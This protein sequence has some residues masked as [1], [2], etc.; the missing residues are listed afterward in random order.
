MADDDLELQDPQTLSF[1]SHFWSE[2]FI[3]ASETKPEERKKGKLPR[4]VGF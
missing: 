2:C 1:L 4:G 3:T